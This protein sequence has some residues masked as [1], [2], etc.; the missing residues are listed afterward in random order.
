MQSSWMTAKAKGI[1]P[2]WSVGFE[3]RRAVSTAA[4]CVMG[5]IQRW[6]PN[7]GSVSSQA[8]PRL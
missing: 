8:S 7:G 5:T 1:S 6:R 4:R 3:T 2:P